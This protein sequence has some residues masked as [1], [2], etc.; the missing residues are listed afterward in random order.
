MHIPLLSN[1]LLDEAVVFRNI[2]KFTIGL[3][4]NKTQ[5][6]SIECDFLFLFTGG[7]FSSN[8]FFLLR[9][10]FFLLLAI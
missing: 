10:E 9:K 4:T 8:L 6:V 1:C 3:F 7:K 5:H 2:P